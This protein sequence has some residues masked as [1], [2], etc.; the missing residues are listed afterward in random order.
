[1]LSDYLNNDEKRVVVKD[2]PRDRVESKIKR[3]KEFINV[4]LS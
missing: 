1:M 4:S 3:F 2:L